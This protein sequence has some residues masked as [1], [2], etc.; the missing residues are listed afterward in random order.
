MSTEHHKPFPED[1]DPT[2]KT[3]TSPHNM[4]RTVDIGEVFTIFD[5]PHTEIEGEQFDRTFAKEIYRA[6]WK[7]E[8]ETTLEGEINFLS[9]VSVRVPGLEHP[10]PFTFESLPEAVEGYTPFDPQVGEAIE[11]LKAFGD[12]ISPRNPEIARLK[13]IAKEYAGKSG[14]IQ[15]HVETSE[16]ADLGYREEE[17]VFVSSGI[18][19]T[20]HDFVPEVSNV[21][22]SL[23]LVLIFPE[24]EYVGKPG[25]EHSLG[26]AMHY[27]SSF[28]PVS[29]PQKKPQFLY[30]P[31]TPRWFEQIRARFELPQEDKPA[32]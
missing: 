26:E 30:A 7:K 4:G 23:H 11:A 3:E 28:A 19:D 2:K 8:P 12:H 20:Y 16:V 14:S 31:H 32:Q 22:N 9:R 18:A 29:D 27:Y 24:E 10:I 25:R 6:Y 13:A 15:A 1:Q 17:P 5:R 21:L